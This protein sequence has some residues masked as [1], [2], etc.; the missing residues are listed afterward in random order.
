GDAPTDGEPVQ[1]PDI[2]GFGAA[3]AVMGLLVWVGLAGRRR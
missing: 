1:T 3:V 2:P